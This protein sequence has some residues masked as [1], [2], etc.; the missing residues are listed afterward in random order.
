MRGWVCEPDAA[1]NSAPGVLVIHEATGLVPNI[2]PVLRRFAEN[3]YVAMAPDLFD[4]AGSKPLCVART[5]LTMV[6]GKGD[7]MDDLASAKDYLKEHRLCNPDRLG[8]AG[9]CMGGGF[10]LLMALT[11]DVKAS[12]PYYGMSP[13]YLEQIENS[14]PVIASYGGRDALMKPAWP[15]LKKALKSSSIPHEFKVYP[16]AGH[17]YFTEDQPGVLFQMGKAGPLKVG[18]RPDDAEDSWQRMLSFFGEH[19]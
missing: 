10:S 1:E 3:G 4:K 15:R 17:S 11:S 7:A 6:T 5:M 8:V 2:K 16:D 19:I 13:V 9:F 12:A 14:C 18:Y